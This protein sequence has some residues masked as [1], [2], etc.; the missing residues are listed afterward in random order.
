V[1]SYTGAISYQ[2]D[3]AY[4]IP[5]A[6]GRTR[7][8]SS[9]EK[10]SEKSNKNYDY[11]VV[12]SAKIGDFFL[13]EAFKA[14]LNVERKKLDDY[15]TKWLHAFYVSHDNPFQITTDL[16]KQLANRETMQESKWRTVLNKS[17]AKVKQATGWLV[18]EV[19]EF[20]NASPKI[21]IIKRKGKSRR[22]AQTGDGDDGA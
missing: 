6:I 12:I 18:C 14:L 22:P 16:I 9:L 20:E 15:L 3:I 19:K 7:L 17:L 2:A 21:V 4:E 10:V 1:S 11:E 13:G 8:I 5:H